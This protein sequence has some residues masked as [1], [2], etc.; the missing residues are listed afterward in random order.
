MTEVDESKM[1][2]PNYVFI[3]KGVDGEWQLEIPHEYQSQFTPIKKETYD[4]WLQEKLDNPS[5]QDLEEMKA[6]EVE[7]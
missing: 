7:S 5:E 1:E 3:K 4:R 2:C 6:Y